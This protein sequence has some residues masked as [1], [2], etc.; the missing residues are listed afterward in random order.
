MALSKNDLW[1]NRD[2]LDDD[3]VRQPQLF[4]Q[5]SEEHARLVSERDA[6]K[7]HLEEV[8]AK[9]SREIREQFESDGRKI[10]EAVVAAEISLR[11]EHRAATAELNDLRLETDRA[12]AMKEAFS[13]RAYALKDLA[14]LFSAGYWQSASARGPET[15]EAQERAIQENRKSVS[16]V[17][18]ER[19]QKKEGK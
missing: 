8:D 3:L 2:A 4:Y 19:L 16:Q 9:L 10:T 5:A 13:Q 12:V 1:I 11:S 7:T 18:R 14:G 6:A 17:R 15:R